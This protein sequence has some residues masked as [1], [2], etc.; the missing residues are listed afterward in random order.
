[1]DTPAP[2]IPK[3]M[4]GINACLW[5][6]CCTIKGAF[7]CYCSMSVRAAIQGGATERWKGVTSSLV[8]VPQCTSED[9]GGGRGREVLEEGV[10]PLRRHDGY[11]KMTGIKL[12]C[13]G[14]IIPTL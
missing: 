9:A 8:S 5:M 7:D 12:S 3:C 14:E 11:H 6:V 10:S 1:M 2:A 13:N 4:M